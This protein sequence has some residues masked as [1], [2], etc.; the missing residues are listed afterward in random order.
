VEPKEGAEARDLF[1]NKGEDK[2]T[3]GVH[4]DAVNRRA[5]SK[6]GFNLL[7]L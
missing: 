2:P 1:P 3:G 6:E 5:R 4:A 7:T